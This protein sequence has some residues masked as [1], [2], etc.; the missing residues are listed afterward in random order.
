MSQPESTSFCPVLWSANV[1]PVACAALKISK[2]WFLL[3]APTCESSGL[4]TG[5]WSAIR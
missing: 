3:E 2:V 1:I 4:N 5:T